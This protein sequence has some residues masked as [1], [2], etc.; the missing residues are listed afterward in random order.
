MSGVG[1]LGRVLSDLMPAISGKTWHDPFVINT[2]NIAFAYSW[3]A[4]SYRF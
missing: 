3:G 1:I 4:V 2:I